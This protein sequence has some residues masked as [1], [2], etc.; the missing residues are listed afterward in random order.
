MRALARL[1]A[2]TGALLLASPAAGDGVQTIAAWSSPRSTTTLAIATSETRG[3]RTAAVAL[4]SGGVDSSGAYKRVIV[5][6]EKQDWPVFE[7]MWDNAR[8]CVALASEECSTHSYQDTPD[9]TRLSILPDEANLAIE[10]A[11]S[12]LHG[13]RLYFVFSQE[14][15]RGLAKMRGAIRTVSAYLNQ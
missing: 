11:A 10:I 9:G 1:A 6:F 4:D 12:D 5:I 3:L 14:D 8:G 7:E 13:N 15:L 2:A